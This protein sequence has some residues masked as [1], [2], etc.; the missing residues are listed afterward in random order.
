M[1]WAVDRDIR[2]IADEIYDRLVYEPA[3]PASLSVHFARHPDHV[4]IVGGLSKSFAMTGWRVGYCLAHPEVVRA[5][6]TLQS[7]STSNVC[8]VAQKAAIAALTGPMDCVE[9]MRRTFAHRRDLSLA[10]MAGWDRAVCPRPDGAFYLFPSVAAYYTPAI[11]NST[12]LSEA[13]LTEI[14]VA[15]VPGAAFGDDRCVRFSY[16]TSDAVL[17]SALTLVGN[18]LKKL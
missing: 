12:A 13:L 11:P 5:M 15:S 18:F 10:I 4:A 1:D 17:E 16:A 3:T 2:I 14:G 9:R 6:T 8:T 7:Q